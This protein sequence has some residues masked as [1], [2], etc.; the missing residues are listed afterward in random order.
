MKETKYMKKIILLHQEFY[1][2]DIIRH[3]QQR[4]H[5]KIFR[6]VIRDLLRVD[7]AMVAYAIKQIV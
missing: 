5:G 2:K 6:L 1:P 3:A 4:S 7:K